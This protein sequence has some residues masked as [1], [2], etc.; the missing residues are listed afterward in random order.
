MVVLNQLTLP[1][2]TAVHD[3]YIYPINL[4]YHFKLKDK[5]TTYT[6]LFIMY[7]LHIMNTSILPHSTKFSTEFKTTGSSGLMFY[8]ADAKHS[9][10]I[11]LYMHNGKL[12]LSFNCGSGLATLKTG[13]KYNDGRWH[14]VNTIL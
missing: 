2:I 13:A 10:F 9:D 1:C 14:R 5:P 12:A 3:S 4:A 11:G 7:K 6:L 8:I